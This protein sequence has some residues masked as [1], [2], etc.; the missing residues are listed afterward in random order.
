MSLSGA[1]TSAVTGID[2]QSQALGAISDNIS[3]SQ[4][5]GYKRVDTQFSTLLTVSNALVHDPGGVTSKPLYTNGIQGNVQQTSVETNLA[6]SGDGFF[7]VSQI[8]S[9]NGQGLPSFAPDPLFTR[10]GDFSVDNN[11]FL[12]NNAGYVLNGFAIDQKTGQVLKNAVVP[13]QL[14]QLKTNPVATAN[15]TY[16]A[17][18]PTNPPSTLNTGP[19]APITVGRTLT[20]PTT[21]SAP[22]F[23][24]GNTITVTPT[25]GPAV[26]FVLSDQSLGAGAA[27]AGPG[28]VQVNFNVGGV[29]NTPSQILSLLATS[30]TQNG[31]SSSIDASNSNL[32]IDGTPSNPVTAV[33]TGG[34]AL[35]G[36]TTSAATIPANIQFAPSTV[37]FFDAQGAAHVVNVNWTK[38]SGT[39]DT[40]TVTYTSTDP[41]IT[42]ILPI[43][44]TTVVF[45]VVDNALTGAKA[46]SIKS[47]NGVAGGVG[48]AATVPLTVNFNGTTPTSQPINFNLGSYGIASQTTMFTGTDINFISAQQDGLPPGSFRDLNIDSHG[49]ITLNYDN[50]ARKTEFQVPL[51]SFSDPNGLQSQNGNAYSTTVASGTPSVQS[52]GDNGTGT[53]VPSSVE[54]SNVDIAAEFTKLIQTQRAYEANTK[55][56]TTTNQLLQE[57]NNLIQ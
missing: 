51:A 3:N 37:N 53:I 17:N 22:N 19:T 24:N 41:T 12:V 31:F 4:T 34:A 26:T 2:A 39:N 47:I 45:N 29:T 1:L 18:L 7:S 40:Y 36:T 54:G 49:N 30:L 52:P 46:G 44:P 10:A 38:V 6:I 23:A 11:G 25:T 16:S 43:T 42:S 56:V 9:V 5:T 20:W 35:A 50:G 55:V 32:T 13:I 48:T 28:Q 57:T 14:N 15:I 8:T 33:S 27:T 21:P